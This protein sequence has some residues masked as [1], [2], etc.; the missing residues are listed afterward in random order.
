MKK[1]LYLLLLTPI[2]Y[3]VSCSSGKSN[4][5][6]EIKTIEETIVGLNWELLNYEGGWFRLNDDYTFSTKITSCDPYTI[7]G[8]WLLDENI[9]IVN[10]NIAGEL[11]TSTNTVIS[12]SD[13]LLI[14]SSDTSLISD[15]YL[16]FKSTFI[17][18]LNS[19]EGCTDLASPN[20]NPNA[21]QDDGSCI[22]IGD[23]YQGGFIF[24][25]DGNG[26]G[27]IASPSDNS[28]SEKW[29]CFGVIIPTLSNIGSGIQNT[30]N[31]E[32][33]CSETETAVYLCSNLTYNGY[34]DWFLPSLFELN[35]MYKMKNVVDD[36]G[37]F[38]NSFY[39]SSTQSSNSHAYAID[40]GS[41][42]EYELN[43]GQSNSRVRA[44]RAF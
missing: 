27:L 7:E 21:C 31:F 24:W 32:A 41:G 15:T 3:L 5:T 22:G 37:Q 19:I 42:H 30:I 6:H 28:S 9:L 16:S 8:D 33:Y 29:G 23:Y 1:L 38:N 26:G 2:I 44:V 39:W 35:E 12:F 10:Y 4:L 34:S 25:M 43:K 17:D 20:Y 11:I 40:F 14:I 18:T 36:L 13:S